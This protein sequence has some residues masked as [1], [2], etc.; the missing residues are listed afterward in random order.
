MDQ[1]DQNG[2]KNGESGQFRSDNQPSSEAKRAGWARRKQAQEFMDT[3]MFY[4][5]LT[6][7]ELYIL[8]KEAKS[9]KANIT[10]KELIALTYTSKLLTT[11]KFLLDWLDRHI[12]RASSNLFDEKDGEEKIDKIIVQIVEPNGNITLY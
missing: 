9:K 10:I 5:N 4:Q 6:V 1:K 12:G 8:E 7:K 3:M 2:V 11:D